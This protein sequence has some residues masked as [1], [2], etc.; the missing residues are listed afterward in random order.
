MTVDLDDV[1]PVDEY[2]EGWVCRA[3]FAPDT[4]KKMANYAEQTMSNRVLIKPSVGKPLLYYPDGWDI[5]HQ[6]FAATVA[7]VLGDNLV[8]IG[9]L[10]G[11]GLAHAKSNVLLLHS[12]GPFPEGGGYCTWSQE[13]VERARED[14]WKSGGR[15]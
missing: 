15:L 5:H 1:D 7:H 3:G 6:P 4:G 12:D 9:Y 10:D 8:N 13:Q 2:L 14:A 11:D